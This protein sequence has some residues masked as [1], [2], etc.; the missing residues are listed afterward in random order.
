MSTLLQSTFWALFVIAPY[1]GADDLLQRDFSGLTMPADK[2]PKTDLYGDAIPQNAIRRLGTIRFRHGS[3]VTSNAFSPDGI[4]IA[5]GDL[6]GLVR[7]WKPGSGEQVGILENHDKPITAL[8]FSGNAKHFA[9]AAADG[10]IAI[11]HLPDHKKLWD[12]TSD[13]ITF[14]I[15]FSPDGQTLAS[16]GTKGVVRIWKTSDG[17]EMQQIGG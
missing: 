3:N 7:F 13:E 17:K 1:F 16:I 8:A 6:D 15:V 10:K 11:W 5:S 12:V 14:A 4:V 2:S 9:T